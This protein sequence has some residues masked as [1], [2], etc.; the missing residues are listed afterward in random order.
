MI[1]G[2]GLVKPC[3]GAKAEVPMTSDMIA[4]AR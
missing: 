2:S 4:A 1:V 3:E